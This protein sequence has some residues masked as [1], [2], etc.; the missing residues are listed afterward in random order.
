MA[1]FNLELE[2]RTATVIHSSN[3]SSRFGAWTDC[4]IVDCKWWLMPETYA[5]LGAVVP[6]SCKL[7]HLPHCRQWHSRTAPKK[8]PAKHIIKPLLEDNHF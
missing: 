7:A 4:E 3:E 8:F 2:P 1:K 5:Q 6:A